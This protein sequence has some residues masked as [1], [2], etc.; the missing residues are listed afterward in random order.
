MGAGVSGW[1][2]ARAVSTLGQLGVVSGTALDTILVRRLQDGD[3]GGHMRRAL[4]V[5]P[6]PAV[7]RRALDK[8]FRSSSAPRAPEA[9]PRYQPIPLLR[10][11]LTPEREALLILANFVEVYL[12]REGH[13][14]L[15][16][17]NFLE[18]IQMAIL[19]SLYGAML[20]G[21]GVV[22]I[23][24]GIPAEI[25]AVLD[26]LAR[27]EPAS[28]S[29][30]VLERGEDHYELRFDPALHW[31]AEG[32]SPP[33]IERP[34]FLPIVASATLARA[35][36]KK[37]PTGIHGFVVEGP[38]A[39]GHNAPPRG[40]L[41]L[42]SRGEP[43]YGERDAVDPASMS[44]LGLPFWL[45]GARASRDRLAAAVAS[46]AQGIQAGTLFAFCLESGLDPELKRQLLARVLAG[47]GE[48]FTDP[49]ASPTGYPFKVAT[50]EGTLS[51]PEQAGE[52]TRLCDLGYLRRAYRKS[53]GTLGYRCPS[54][55][56]DDYLAKGGLLEET[57]GRK[58]LC[59]ALMANIGME[60]RREDGYR[61][62]PMLTAGDDLDC[63]RPFITTERL[64]YHAKDV[65]DA[66]LAP[67]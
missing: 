22:L 53:D 2:L 60:Q 38:V 24:A 50:L 29:L 64:D 14:G 12:A 6:L 62:L 52:R 9:S 44:A 55:P 42:T 47:A 59:N 35:L 20:A 54:E 4:E 58:C 13:S 18:K 51:Q 56:I 25:P 40:E 15:V 67:A 10:A 66:L 7:A 28:I 3:P 5:F 33:S 61:E 34:R 43:I 8:Y 17:I 27:H 36:L 31:D 39:G 48:V 23:G 19:P 32:R 16:G 57:A 21:V 37:A 45:A 65:I 30:D 41:R 1:R 11:T 26:L 63:I 46:G 49:V